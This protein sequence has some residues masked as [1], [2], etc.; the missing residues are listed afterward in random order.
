MSSR[1]LT[2]AALLA[3]ALALAPAASRAEDPAP[4]AAAEKAQHD[5]T[6]PAVTDT[7]PGDF[8]PATNSIRRPAYKN[9]LG[10][11]P[12]VA[13]LDNGLGQSA[14]SLSGYFWEDAGYM[15]TKNQQ[16]GLYDQKASY[17][18]GRLVLRAEYQRF[19]V[20]DLFAAARAEIIA[21]ENEYTKSQYEPH[22]LEA[23]AKIG[24]KRWDVQVGR[25][26]PFMVYYRGLGVDLYTPEETGAGGSV[27]TI[28]HLNYAWGLQDEPGQLAVHVF[29]IDGLGIEVSGVY[30]Q[31]GTSGLNTYALR[32]AVDWKRGGLEVVAGAEYFIQR[33]Q[34]SEFKVELTQYG[35]GGRVQYTFG[36]LTA[37][38][39]G[40]YAHSEKINI[41]EE[42]DGEQTYHRYSV[43]GWVDLYF[44][45][46]VLSL[47]LHHTA[48]S[49][50]NGD[51]PT[52]QQGYVAL[53]HRLPVNGLSLKLVYGIGLGHVDDETS[54]QQFD[55]RVQSVRARLQYL[56]Q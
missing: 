53:I 13:F 11:E 41:N 39:E 32:P 43:G 6:P 51:K 42:R 23:W 7:P 37:G 19:L 14:L 24:Q 28:Y 1:P 22:T 12:I 30:G 2:S 38:V 25:F 48:E 50:L 40:A 31:T 52:Q 46:D 16:P 5:N 45:N 47:G 29:P 20:S 18:Q 36:L 44:W 4:G 3:L 15:L 35:A 27:P 17:M 9:L 56:F 26:F 54:H 34:R 49:R 21:F 33:P 10:K 55:N 8:G